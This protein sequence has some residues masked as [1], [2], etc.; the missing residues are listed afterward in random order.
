MFFFVFNDFY[1]T[2]FESSPLPEDRLRSVFVKFGKSP[3]HGFQLARKKAAEAEWELS[4][5]ILLRGI[6]DVQTFAVF[7]GGSNFDAEP[8]MKASSQ[9]L[10]IIPGE[11]RVGRFTLAS[12]YIAKRLYSEVLSHNAR[13]FWEFFNQFMQSPQSRT[14]AG[15]LWEN[16]VL[17][18]VLSN[19]HNQME[20]F[21]LTPLPL[22][23]SLSPLSCVELPFPIVVTFADKHDLAQQLVCHAP[24]LVKG[25][26]IL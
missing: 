16:H 26:R 7:L 8:A 9:L 12:E 25:T 6:P 19:Q 13:K 3:R 5:T 4:I 20:K 1:R 2:C 23:Q 15:W 24:E 21:D 14:A 22:A 18:K 10:T 17:H 11:N